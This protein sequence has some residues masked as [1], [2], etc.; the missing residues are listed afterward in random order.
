MLYVS[1]LN[2]TAHS[3]LKNIGAWV[4][5]QVF[6]IQEIASHLSVLTTH[7]LTVT[8]RLVRTAREEQDRGS[9][10]RVRG[11]LEKQF[12]CVPS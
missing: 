9:D 12:I 7:S 1:Y 4:L 2:Q 6:L 11:C 8:D 5:F 10:D 3:V